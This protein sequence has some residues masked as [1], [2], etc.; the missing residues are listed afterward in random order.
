MCPCTLPSSIGRWV[1]EV[2]ADKDLGGANF[3]ANLKQGQSALRRFGSEALTKLLDD[4]GLGSHPEFVRLFAK[5]GK[6]IAEDSVAGTTGGTRQDSSEQQILQQ[7]Y[8]KMFENGAQR[9]T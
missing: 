4:S 5:V 2:K 1:D 8:P 6:A 7:L 9:A 3:D